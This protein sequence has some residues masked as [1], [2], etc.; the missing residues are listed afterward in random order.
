MNKETKRQKI[1][2]WTNNIYK[3]ISNCILLV[4]P[5]ILVLIFIITPIYYRV[6]DFLPVIASALEI[7][8]VFIVF[9]SEIFSSS[10]RKR[11]SNPKLVNGIKTPFTQKNEYIEKDGKKYYYFIGFGRI[12]K[13]FLLQ[14]DRYLNCIQYIRTGWYWLKNEPNEK[15]CKID[16]DISATEKGSNRDLQN[17]VDDL[18]KYSKEKVFGYVLIFIGFVAQ[19]IY[20]LKVL[21][22]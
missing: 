16:F 21:I 3:I 15:N 13:Q 9:V 8:G 11:W 7:Y 2:R 5:P 19:L 20:N 12:L 1:Y 4:S 6:Y 17:Q 10:L 14:V 18:K 22:N